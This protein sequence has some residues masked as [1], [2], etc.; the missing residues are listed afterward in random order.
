MA[1]QYDGSVVINTE[2]D[3]S[4]FDKGSERLEAAIKELT[5][6][7]QRLGQSMKSSFESY[8]QAIQTAI[9]STASMQQ[10][11]QSTESTAT[12][13]AQAVQETAS[14]V[15]SMEQAMETTQTSAAKTAQAVNETTQ[16][17][18]N[19]NQASEDSVP[20]TDLGGTATLD[21]KTLDKDISALQKKVQKVQEM[22]KGYDAARQSANQLETELKKLGAQKLPADD[23]K[24]IGDEIDK[25]SKKLEQLEDKEAKMKSLGVNPDSMGFKSLQY[26]IDQARANLGQLIND[27]E[28]MEQ[29]G[30]AFVSGADTA[31]FKQAEAA[32]SAIKGQ[33][34]GIR[35]QNGLSAI[36]NSLKTVAS[37][38]LTA[39]KSL[40]SMA[41]AGLST[42][43]RK[44][45][46]AVSNMG[47]STKSANSGF[48]GGLKAMMK[49]GIGV[50]SLF[51][52][53]NRL[54]RVMSESLGS[55]ANYDPAF[56]SVMSSFIG[57][58]KQLGNAFAGAFAPV[59]SVV[60]PI[61]TTLINALSEAVNR[62]G[63][64]LASLTGK[65]SF[66]KATKVQYD[67]AKASNKA[68]GS[69]DDEA[70]AAKEAKK[71]LMGFDQ[72]N[73]LSEDKDKDK[74]GA[75]GNGAGGWTEVPVDDTANAWADMLRK[76]WKEADFTD[77]GRMVGEKLNEALEKIPWNKIKK[78]L[79]KVAKSIATFL[80]G[81]LETPK[82]F[83]NIGKTIAEGMNSAFEFVDSF[84]QNFHWDS[85]GQAIHDAI[86]GVCDALDWSVIYR[87]FRGLGSGIGEAINYAI[88]SRTLWS[89]AMTTAANAINALAAGID[90]FAKSVYWGMIGTDIATGLNAGI[91]AIDWGGLATMLINSVNGLFSIL[92][93]FMVNF[94]FWGFGNLIG[95]G[96]STAITGINWFDGAYSVG[97]AITGLLAAFMGFVQGIDWAEVG[98]SVI[99]VIAGFFA[100]FDWGTVGEFISAC[101][102]ALYDFFS[103][104]VAEINWDEVGEY[105]LQAVCDFFEDFDW[106][107]VC[108]G[109]GK[110]I[111]TAFMAVV[112]LGGWLWNKMKEF[113]KNIIEGGW[114]GITEK[115][116]GVGR[117]I[118]ENVF[119]PFI[120]GFKSAFGIHS[121]S[122]EMEPLGGFIISGLL[123]G[124]TGAWHTVT[125]FFWGC[126]EA[127]S[128]IFDGL[129]DW[130]S[131]IGSW[132]VAG[133]GGGIAGAWDGLVTSVT[134]WCSDLWDSIT[135]FFKIGSPSKL[136][137]DTVGRWIPAGVAEGI[138]DTAHTAVD[139][140]RDM[141][142]SIAD[143]AEGTQAIMPIEAAFSDGTTGL[144][145]VMTSFADRV[146]SSFASL[147]SSLDRLVAGSD[148]RMPAVA[149]GS[150]TPYSARSGRSGRSVAGGSSLSSQYPDG[151]TKEE[152]RS[153]LQDLG[154]KIENISFYISD[155]NLA[156][157][158]NQ[159]NAVLD[160]RY[161]VG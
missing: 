57:S 16:A 15:D 102:I 153:M 117:W 61:L 111:G 119:D 140:V 37:R 97:A 38:A 3:K 26:D 6:E 76:A 81:F 149:T 90:A 24:W 40:A 78:T 20:M 130:W 22:G 25:V 155:E 53:L 47:K 18:Q 41:K 158:V 113:G 142:K 31:Q 83:T 10:T 12:S 104:A 9:T 85:L 148:F 4:G 126:G 125:D 60:L 141:A 27:K 74:K 139:S 132:I 33:L 109:V 156:R 50:R 89:S 107:G 2:L 100:G 80:N 143:E 72:V 39:A 36:S 98:R 46:S 138:D 58:L 128:N 28:A 112:K 91:Q 17:V 157:H 73:I 95:T 103:G 63:M 30:R 13:T 134:S 55:L 88:G 62:I 66:V 146:A 127:I 65:G 64:M 131:S 123:E 45:G 105:I 120:N 101:W 94:D 11:M 118:K 54:R 161:K 137:R 7:V 32:L 44:I 133:I 21:T 43:F 49:Y 154:R 96:L 68:A 122:K 19:L 129:S 110:A 136:M 84:V 145:N 70:D 114:K 69:L 106:S 159:G 35:R 79:R 150:V 121:P 147:L 59:L 34:Q 1:Q 48:W 108:E 29:S 124:I 56:N 160:R 82:L 152:L 42:A 86:Q 23:Y 8:A 87:T 135:G 144:D 99:D 51:A 52:L 5:A 67:Y 77:I 151:I 115:I 14:A 93:S 116:A 92:F 71:Q 75:D